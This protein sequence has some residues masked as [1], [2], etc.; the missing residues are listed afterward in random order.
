MD[1]LAIADAATLRRGLTPLVEGYRTWLDGQIALLDG[2]PVSLRGTGEHALD[3]AREIADR[4]EAGVGLLTDPSRPGHADALKAFG[5]ANHVMALQRRNTAAARIREEQGL[6][7]AEAFAALADP[8]NASWRPFQLAFVLLNLPAIADPAHPERAAAHTAV[9]DLLFF[10]TGGGK[11]EAYLGLTA[12]TFAIRR[13][14]GQVGAGTDQRDGSDG[15]AV[16]MRYTLRLLTAQQ[17]QRAA[18]LVCAAEFVRREDP[19]TWG[20]AP[21]RIGLWVGGKVS[22]NW[23]P[24]AEEQV[25]EAR[26][27][28]KDQRVNVLQTLSCPWCGT[29]GRAPRPARGRDRPSDPAVLPQRR[30]RRGLPVLAAQGRRGGTAGPDR[31]RGDLP[32]HARAGDRDRRQVRA[33]PVA[34]VRRVAVRAGARAMPAAWLQ[35]RGPRR[36]H[37]LS[38]PARREG[39]APGGVRQ[40]GR[41]ATTAGPDHPGRAAPDLGALGTTVGLFEAAIDELST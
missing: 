2:I 25:K 4:I 24:Q 41:P 33:T 37:Q 32:V 5:F 1:A 10:P 3:K 36:P 28:G 11:T 17:F 21:F 39:P 29:P 16:L 6:D 12:F 23:Y 8:K 35:A 7:Y 13:L 22:P 26:E 27:A 31:R 19:G 38:R 20:Q 18:A 34:R 15:V 9:V 40:A 14:L 30:G